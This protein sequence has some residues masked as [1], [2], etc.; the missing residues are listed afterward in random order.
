[1]K[2]AIILALTLATSTAFAAVPRGSIDTDM[3]Y[4]GRTAQT[5]PEPYVAASS[6]TVDRSRLDGSLL[7]GG[8]TAQVTPSP[9]TAPGPQR[10]DRGQIDTDLLYSGV[11]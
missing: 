11:S 8:P 2:T 4:G 3:L 9:Y 10:V 5:A 1:M 6:T 7:Y